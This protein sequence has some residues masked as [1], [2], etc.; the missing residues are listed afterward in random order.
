MGDDKKS[1][2]ESTWSSRPEPD[3]GK[4]SLRSEPEI[5][6]EGKNNGTQKRKDSV[7]LPTYHNI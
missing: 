5:E 2:K 1:R 6:T 3:E 4:R 7:T